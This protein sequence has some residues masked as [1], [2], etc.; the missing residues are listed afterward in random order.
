MLGHENPCIMSSN[1]EKSRARKTQSQNLQCNYEWGQEN[2]RAKSTNR[3]RKT[4]GRIHHG[5]RYW[6]RKTRISGYRARKIWVSIEHDIRPRKP[7]YLWGI[8]SGKP[9]YHF[10]NGWGIR[11]GKPENQNPHGVRY[12]ARKTWISMGQEGQENPNAI[13]LLG[14]VSG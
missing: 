8:G 3:A 12:Q 11:P 2:P 9:E 13:L 1:G 4:W 10:A 5:M 14:E 7:E 6:A